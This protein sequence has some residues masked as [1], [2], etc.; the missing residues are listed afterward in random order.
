MYSLPP[1]NV[2]PN[3]TVHISID[4]CVQCLI[5][6]SDPKVKSIFDVEFFKKLREWNTRYGAKFTCYVYA[7]NG[8]FV[9]SSIPDRFLHEFNEASDYLKFGFHATSSNFE[10]TKA[11]GRLSFTY[12]FINTN[13]EIDRF[14]GQ[15]SRSRI[16]RLDHFFARP[17][18]AL[19]LF[20]ETDY[21]LAPDDNRSAYWLPPADSRS[22]KSNGYLPYDATSIPSKGKGFWSTDAR[23]DNIFWTWY[24]LEKLRH[25]ERLVIFTHE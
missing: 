15:N 19:S 13:R 1:E 10:E 11:Q 17:E 9:I 14:A 22:V 3:K 2:S 21:L 25:H 24:A 5:A 23:Y 4:D 18:W 16:L 7:R 20:S 8:D 6:I 12:S